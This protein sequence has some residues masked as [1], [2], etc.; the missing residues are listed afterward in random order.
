MA[1]TWIEAFRAGELRIN[2][3]MESDKVDE[4]VNRMTERPSDAAINL[5]KKIGSGGL[6]LD[7]DIEVA[8]PGSEIVFLPGGRYSGYEGA[9]Q[10]RGVICAR[11]GSLW[12]GTDSNTAV[13]EVLTGDNKGKVV[14][15][16]YGDLSIYLAPITTAEA[17]TH[18]K[19]IPI[20]LDWS[21]VSTRVFNEIFMG[22]KIGD[23]TDSAADEEEEETNENKA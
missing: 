19:Q 14:A 3:P 7:W 20:D 10:M 6:P 12:P 9:R 23:E 11:L 8:P 4:L 16:S 21:E 22:H 17:I 15:C 2:E 18:V 1:K 13:L 5:W